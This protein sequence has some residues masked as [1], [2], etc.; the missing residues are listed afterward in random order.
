MTNAAEARDKLE[1]DEFKGS[2]WARQLK[3][4]AAG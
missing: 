1:G 4:Q 2:E 3:G